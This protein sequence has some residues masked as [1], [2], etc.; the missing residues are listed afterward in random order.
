MFGKKK[1]FRI[2][3]SEPGHFDL[4]MKRFFR[5]MYLYR[6]GKAGPELISF[7]AENEQKAKQ[8]AYFEIKQLEKNP[9]IIRL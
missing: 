4:Q 5:W 9:K 6:G 3:E 8:M 2:I 1:K 7:E